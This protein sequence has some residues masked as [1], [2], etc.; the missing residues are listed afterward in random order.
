MEAP[1]LGSTVQL[2]WG[3]CRV[4]LPTKH[5]HTHTHTLFLVLAVCALSG[6]GGRGPP[7]QT[8]GVRGGKAPP[9]TVRCPSPAFT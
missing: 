6:G 1:N 9:G 4:V 5:T 7:H 8:G 3:T 2:L